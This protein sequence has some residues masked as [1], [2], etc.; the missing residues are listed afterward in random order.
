MVGPWV[1]QN[2]PTSGVK[3]PNPKGFTK[4]ARSHGSER[5]Q[6]LQGSG[7]FSVLARGP[8]GPTG[9]P[10]GSK[11]N[12]Q[13][14]TPEVSVKSLLLRGYFRDVQEPSKTHLL[15]GCWLLEMEVDGWKL[16]KFSELRVLGHAKPLPDNKSI[17]HT[18]IAT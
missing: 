12:F 14:Q 5:I 3:G 16:A 2:W 13:D 7:T 6:A 1:P 11:V 4:P 9:I 17:Q 10:L 15:E 8:V 18:V